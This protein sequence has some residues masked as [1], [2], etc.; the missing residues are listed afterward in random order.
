[1]TAL[2][3][4]DVIT[5]VF[6]L[7]SVL[8]AAG[9]LWQS[10]HYARKQWNLDAFTH[11]AGKYERIMS[12]FPDDA[13]MY[14]FEIDKPIQSNQEVRLAVLKYLNLTSEEYYL[15]KDGY[16]SSEI[17]KIWKPEIIR[18]LQTPLFVREWKNLK[19]EFKSYPE[20]LN[21][22]DRTQEETNLISIKY[23]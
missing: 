9:A 7:G 13:Y 19:H 17:W 4:F 1:M 16:I 21:F 8:L 18:T 2:E 22:V 10:S 12:S 6:G 11:Y 3:I 20:F 14:R 15:Q 23:P 5:K